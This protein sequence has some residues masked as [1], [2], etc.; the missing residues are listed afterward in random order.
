MIIDAHTHGMHGGSLD[1]LAKAGGKWGEKRV[2]FARA[3]S[4]RKPS[5][6]DVKVR[7]EQMDRTGIDYQV[8]TAQWTFDCNLLPGHV[9]RQLAYAQALNENLAR[10]A[11]EAGGR[12]LGIATVPL[13]DYEEHGRKELERAL[14]ELGLRAVAVSTNLLGKPIDL[15]EYEA[16][17]AHAQE[18]DVPVFIHPAD[19]AS[20][21][22]RPYEDEYDLMHNYGWPFE[23]MLALS[24]L[25]F[26]GLMEKY[27]RLKVVGHHLGGGIPFYFGRT[28]ET[29]TTATNVN[30]R[31]PS[32]SSHEQ[33]IRKIG[34]IF[35][36]P[37]FEY[38]ARFYYD[39][40]IGG[41]APAIRCAYDVFGADRIVFATD[42]PFGPGTGEERLASYPGVIR[43]LGFSEAVNRKIFSENAR[44]MLNLD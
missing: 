24:R 16:F 41:S 6:S 39:T 10:F 44:R 9:K 27:P 37:M 28:M 8:F 13:A 34:R 29:Y 3:Q 22:G 43:S 33:L 38:F 36:R 21:A 1:L 15:P 17:W 30:W 4:L 11:A 18:L 14:K 25:V 35:D 12:L 7:L 42:A 19:A 2:E 26:S 40:A 31:E 23:S 20:N 5:F 32:D